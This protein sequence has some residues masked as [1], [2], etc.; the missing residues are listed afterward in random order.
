MIIHHKVFYFSVIWL[1]FKLWNDFYLGVSN[2]SSNDSSGS[3]NTCD[4]GNSG[5]DSNND[6]D[7]D[8]SQGATSNSDDSTSQGILF[9]R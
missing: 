4:S 8:S 9:F 1:V 5:F 7:S 3:S 6:G 2:S